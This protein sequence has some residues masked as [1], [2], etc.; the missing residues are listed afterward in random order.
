MTAVPATV[1]SVVINGGNGQ[2]SSVTS[3][4]VTFDSEVDHAALNSAFSVTNIST[5]TAVGTVSVA[6]TDN[7]G[8][9]TA[10][11]TF[12]GTSTLPPQLGTFATTLIDGNYRLDILASQVQLAAN[13]SVT[14][15]ADYVFGNQTFGEPNNDDFF[16]LYGD[17]NG[18]GFTTNLEYFFSMLPAI[19]SQT[20]DPTYAEPLDANGDGFITNFEA[21][22]DFLPRI[23]QQR[24]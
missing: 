10:I 5:S 15:A 12:S 14:M 1:E 24:D 6:A 17:V 20:G 16:R 9:T 18:D 21:F 22:F 4:T 7:L 8:K 3:V 2:R 11:V 23:G 19:G 13:N